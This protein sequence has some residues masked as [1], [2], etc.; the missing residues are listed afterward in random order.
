MK[1]Y[2][3]TII[4]FI[5][6]LS[7]QNDDGTSTN[8]NPDPPVNSTVTDIDG[9]VYKT[10]KIGTQTWM[11]E[12]LK[13]FKYRN[14]DFIGQVYSDGIRTNGQIWEYLNNQLIGALCLYEDKPSNEITYGLLYNWYAVSDPRGLAPEGWHIPTKEEWITLSEYLGGDNLAGGQ[15]KATTLWASPNT[16]ATNS[17][18]FRALPGGSRNNHYIPRLTDGV[19]VFSGLLTNGYWWSSTS[20]DE[21]NAEFVGLSYYDDKFSIDAFTDFYSDKGYGLSIRCIKD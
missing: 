10:I 13:V 18:G 16:G 3:F 6:F 14:G 9:N 17:S 1:K 2:F 15:L 8:N 21:K 7:C 20:I 5:M 4:V 19:G 12:N 11:A